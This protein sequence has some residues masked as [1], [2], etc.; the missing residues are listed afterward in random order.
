MRV[1]NRT[2]LESLPKR[3]REL[4]ESNAKILD[5]VVKTVSNK[6][7]VSL[8]QIRISNCVPYTIVSQGVTNPP[9]PFSNPDPEEERP[10]EPCKAQAQNK[11]PSAIEKNELTSVEEVEEYL[12]M[13]AA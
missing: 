6:K 1:N 4:T 8:L 3:Q 9:I 11:T 2:L 5:L 7:K 13:E 12:T 10:S